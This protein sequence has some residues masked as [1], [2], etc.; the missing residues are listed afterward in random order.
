[1]LNCFSQEAAEPFFEINEHLSGQRPVRLL[2][3]PLPNCNQ[4]PE[5]YSEKR[6]AWL[7]QLSDCRQKTA[8]ILHGIA[9]NGPESTSLADLARM[10]ALWTKQFEQ[11]IYTEPPVTCS[12]NK[13]CTT[14]HLE[15]YLLHQPILQLVA[16]L[17]AQEYTPEQTGPWSHGLLAVLSNRS[18]TCKG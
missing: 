13:K 16:K 11:N 2:R 17:C 8:E 12:P 3:L 1:M 15:I 5:N 14:P 18:S 6:H 10:A 7:D 9:L 4:D